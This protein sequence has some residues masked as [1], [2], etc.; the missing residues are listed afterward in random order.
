MDRRVFLKS[1]LA[2]AGIVGFS[3]SFS[4]EAKLSHSELLFNKIQENYKNKLQLDGDLLEIINSSINNLSKSSVFLTKNQENLV[5]NKVIDLVKYFK[6]NSSLM[7]NPFSKNEVGFDILITT[8]LLSGIDNI[9]YGAISVGEYGRNI[10]PC[11]KMLETINN[12]EI[13]NFQ[14][15][16]NN[17]CLYD[18]SFGNYINN[19]NSYFIE[20]SEKINIANNRS[21]SRGFFR[22]LF[23][24]VEGGIRIIWRDPPK[25][26]IIAVFGIILIGF[27][28]LLSL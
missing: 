27:V 21:M 11:L 23:D 8:L 9:R 18:D 15:I 13:V 19:N 4:A 16:V 17:A 14:K 26:V 24:S 12:A 10:S 20:H 6:E 7:Y 25:W 3:S 28:I 22:D 5:Y 1:S 2:T